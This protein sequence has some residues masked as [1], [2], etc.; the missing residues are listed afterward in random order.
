MLN[1]TVKEMFKKIKLLGIV[2]LWLFFIYGNVYA[3]DNAHYIRVNI[4]R[5]I[6]SLALRIDGP[7]QIMDFNKNTVLSKGRNINTTVTAY[8][9]GIL[10]GGMNLNSDNIFLKSQD[11]NPIAIDERRFRGEIHFIRKDEHLS[12]INYIELE[13]YIKGI[14]Y[15]EVSHYWPQEALRAQA[16]VCRTFALYQM[17]KNSRKEYDVTN[18]IYSQVYGGKTSE[19]YRTNQAVQETKGLV[20]N[21]KGEIFPTYYHA[22]CAGATEDASLVW[23]TDIPPLRGVVCN[24]CKGSPHYKWHAVLSQEELKEKLAGAGFKINSINN[25][26]AEDKSKS[27]R[28]LNL[29]I[30]GLPEDIQLPAKD[31]REIVGPNVIKSTNFKADVIDRDIIFDGLGW[32]HGIG[33]CQWGAYFM[34]KQGY[35]YREILQYYYPGSSI[36]SID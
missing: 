24:F 21:Y 20:L 10:I 32:G 22:T 2:L 30:I 33:L 1:I 28:I 5:D 8:K 34:A 35:T 23:D 9:N 12:V 13:D 18:D 11:D 19:R 4:L 25:I 15:H 29:K 6:E 14:L 17:D 27:G 36:T 31:F 26:L 3:G 16:I 7:F